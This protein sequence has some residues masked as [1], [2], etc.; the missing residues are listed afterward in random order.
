MG[1]VGEMGWKQTHRGAI[2]TINLG[3]NNTTIHLD[4]QLACQHHKDHLT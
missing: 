1:Y 4:Q 3:K 2:N